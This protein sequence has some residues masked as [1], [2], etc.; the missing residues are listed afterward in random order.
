MA[1]I[2]GWF[3]SKDYTVKLANGDTVVYRNGSA[4]ETGFAVEYPV[5]SR[6]LTGAESDAVFP[7]NT[8]AKSAIGTFR[9]ET[10]ELLHIEGKIGNASVIFAQEGFPVTDV[11]IEGEETTS[12]VDGIPV[13]TGYFITNPDSKGGQRAVFFCS[14]KIGN[15]NVYVE[16]FG[17]KDE[18]SEVS[19]TAADL[20]LQIIENGEPDFSA[21]K[22]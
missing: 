19:R 20:I 14:F 5:T 2:S 15:T 21:V 16:C 17:D 22:K 3:G 4:V 8:E 9:D 10:G 13:T 1:G 7:V 11:V 6:E 12:L 18:A